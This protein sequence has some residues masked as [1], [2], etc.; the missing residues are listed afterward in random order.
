[1]SIGWRKSAMSSTTHAK[2]FTASAMALALVS[3]TA[4]VC[5]AAPTGLDSQSMNHAQPAS[6]TL[7]PRQRA[8]VPIAASAAAGEIARLGPALT[9][10]LDA[11]LT[12]S[13]IKEV[14]VQVYAYAGFPRSL[15]ALTELMTVVETRKRR[16]IQD[17]PGRTPSRPIPKGDALRF[18]G[19]T[20][21]TKLVG[22]PVQG[23]LF[24]FAPVIDEYLKTHLFG[25]IFERDNLDWQSREL[26]TVAMLSSLAGV[27]PQLESHMRISMNVGLTAGQLRQ[28][29]EVL[30]EQ[31]D[32]DSARRARAALSRTLTVA[33][34]R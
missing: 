6:E 21:Q 20:N 7:S 28:L 23:P 13:E 19:T 30:A 11:G 16:G 8:I 17:V 33:S 2:H 12:V 31:V 27:E 22:A 4:A 32:A 26:A 14:L 5:Q 9:Q 18:A 29:V 3:L 10:G 34:A 25:D 1:M 24:D 15:N